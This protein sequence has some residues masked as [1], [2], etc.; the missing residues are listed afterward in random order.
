M[1]LIHLVGNQQ[2]RP[3]SMKMDLHN[4]FK[5]NKI[6]IA[7]RCTCIDKNIR[8][9]GEYQFQPRWL[10]LPIM[11]LKNMYIHMHMSMDAEFPLG[12]L[13]YFYTLAIYLFYKMATVL[14]DFIH[15]CSFFVDI[16]YISPS[17]L[18]MQSYIL[19]FFSLFLFNPIF[20]QAYIEFPMVF[21]SIMN[22]ILEY[23]CC[24]Q[25]FMCCSFFKYVQYSDLT[26]LYTSSSMW[27]QCQE[28]LLLNVSISNILDYRSGHRF[29]IL[30]YNVMRCI[31]LLMCMLLQQDP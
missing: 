7:E 5:Y 2:T 15:I 19:L 10:L 14:G 25:C 22:D 16:A 6:T 21:C 3:K 13:F 28:H 1:L 30:G 4:A 27:N 17:F 26:H 24:R 31:V 12:K 8:Y 9:V 20:S 18:F 23:D 11:I 29:M